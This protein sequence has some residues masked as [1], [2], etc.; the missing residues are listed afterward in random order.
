[1]A[2]KRTPPQTPAAGETPGYAEKQPRDKDDARQPDPKRK[3]N[4]D[5]GGLDREPETTPGD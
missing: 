3:R 5:E 1:M 4:P 2:D